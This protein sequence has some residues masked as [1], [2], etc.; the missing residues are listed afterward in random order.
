MFQAQALVY[1][2]K[3]AAGA[4]KAAE[5]MSSQDS[6][7]LVSSRRRCASAGAVDSL[8]VNVYACAQA[9]S[10]NRFALQPDKA[11]IEQQIKTALARGCVFMVS[12]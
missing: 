9:S 2:A 4:A 5:D 6:A 8:H 10:P 3:A 1:D 12:G 11:Q 7:D